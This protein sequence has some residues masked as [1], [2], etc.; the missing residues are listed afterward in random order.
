MSETREKAE[1][2]AKY[3]DLILGQ[4]KVQLGRGAIGGRSEARQMLKDMLGPAMPS[5]L[6]TGLIIHD[7]DISALGSEKGRVKVKGKTFPYIIEAMSRDACL[8]YIVRMAM[9]VGSMEMKQSDARVALVRMIKDAL[10]DPGC[11]VLS[12]TGK[13]KTPFVYGLHKNLKDIHDNLEKLLMTI[14]L[15]TGSEVVCHA[16]N[17]GVVAKE[18]EAVNDWIDAACASEG[19]AEVF[20]SAL[21]GVMSSRLEE[22]AIIPE[23]EIPQGAKDIVARLSSGGIVAATS[24]FEEEDEADEP[25]AAPKA[26]DEGITFTFDAGMDAA[27]DV[28]LARGTG[29]KYTSH[30]DLERTIAEAMLKAKETDSLKKSLSE[31]RAKAALAPAAPA[32]V[33][34]SGTFPEGETVTRKAYEV[35][36]RK[37]IKAL[38]FEVTCFEWEHAHPLVPAVDESYIFR[39]ELVAAMLYSLMTNEPTWIVG[40]TGTGKTTLVEQLCAR[41]NWPV[42]RINFDS[43]ISRME[44]IGRDTLIADGEG[45]TVSKFEKGVLPQAMEMPCVLICDEIDRIR[46]EVSYVF[47]RA[48]ENNG[49]MLNE[50]GGKLITPNPM[51]RIV[52]T[53][54]TV[55]QGDEMGLYQGARH[56]SAAFLNRFTSWISVDYLSEGQERKLLEGSA[57]VAEG[58]MDM[59]MAY[60]KEHRNAFLNAEILCPISPRSLIKLVQKIEWFASKF[61]DKA[62]IRMAFENTLL[63]G[64]SA[65]DRSVMRGLLDRV[66]REAA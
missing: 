16:I 21:K 8:T 24:A 15:S 59:V 9:A 19:W 48:L 36:G 64:A 63:G 56:Q 35:I 28:I 66:M 13:T 30:K 52:A 62:A 18:I 41:M 3:A 58:H 20:K 42:M 61:D 45:R 11:R 34:S 65:N 43:D 37:K 33:S 26:E 51:F 57:S 2:L 60:V 31:L 6:A 23:D 29:G 7:S 25:E 12:K 47:Q 32:H 38:D 17:T 46:A 53:A 4:V 40:H 54:N 10:L 22:S 14:N 39:P 50:D 49:L 5:E 27:F 1:R 44:L 55:G